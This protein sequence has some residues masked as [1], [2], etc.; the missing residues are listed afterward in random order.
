VKEGCSRG[1]ICKAQR[2]TF[3]IGFIKPAQNSGCLFLS[4]P[5]FKTGKLK[6]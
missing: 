6:S 3:L 2:E 5:I 4:L 1:K